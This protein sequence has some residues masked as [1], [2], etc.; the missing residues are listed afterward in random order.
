MRNDVLIGSEH[1][2]D[3]GSSGD[4]T[5]AVAFG[6]GGARGVAHVHIIEVLD[7][8]GI[9]PVAIAGASI[10]AIMGTAMAAGMSGREVRAHTLHA[11][12]RRSEVV[13]RIWKARPYSM[14]DV[15]TGGLR[16]GQFNIERILRAFLPQNFPTTFEQLQIPTQIVVTDFYA[17]QE[18]VRTSGDLIN[19]VSAS[20]AIPALFRPV[21]CDGRYMIDGGI[22]NPVPFDHLAGMADIVI[23]IDVVGGPSG[24][25][26]D[27]PSTMDLMFGASQLMMQ[28][29]ITMKLKSG[30]PDIFLR[31][32]VN[33][34]RVLDFFKADEILEVSAGVR[35]ELKHAIDAVFT[36]HIKEGG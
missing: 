4:P 35:E 25:D 9:R 30:R 16:L 10:G 34:F 13:S 31:P 1:N 33:R 32:D 18:A 22:F 20:A 21:L 17:Q 7:E 11:L 27:Q 19:A 3:R 8:L 36:Y 12:G 24:D 2:V 14:G 15:M 26:G 23:G 28:S 5:V 6:G 29:I